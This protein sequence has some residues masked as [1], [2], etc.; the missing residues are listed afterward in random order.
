[1]SLAKE[2]KNKFNGLSIDEQ[3]HTYTYKGNVLP[4]VSSIIE[5]LSEE[6]DTLKHA[7]RV[8][9]KEGVTVET[10]IKRW[11]DGNK[12]SCDNGHSVHDFGENYVN[13]KYFQGSDVSVLFSSNGQEEAIIKYWNELP[14]YYLPIIL[15]LK[16]YSKIFGYAGTCDILLYNLKTRKFVIA[17]YKTNIDLFKNFKGQTMLPPFEYLLDM[18]YNHYQIQLSLYEL[19]LEEKGYRIENRVIIWLFPDGTY[20][21]YETNDFRRLIKKYLNENWRC[22]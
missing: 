7:T 3:T 19:L 16:M 17:D 2:L 9:K 22:N 4:S 5:G 1:M 11:E 8:A 13:K 15:E 18:P 20:K 21:T 12:L 10:I 6:F 14:N